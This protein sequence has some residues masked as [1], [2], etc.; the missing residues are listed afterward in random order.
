MVCRPK[1]LRRA[2]CLTV[3]IDDLL[4]ADPVLGLNR[5]TDNH[6]ADPSSDR[7]YSESRSAREIPLL[8][9]SEKY[10]PD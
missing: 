3:G 9:R 8:C 4:M 6:I 7:D 2:G 10:H 5:I 1:R